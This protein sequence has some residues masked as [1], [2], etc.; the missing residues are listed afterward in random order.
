[1]ISLVNRC[2]P[3]WLT[4][5]NE[6][7]AKQIFVNSFLI[8]GGGSAGCV[9]AR[10]LSDEPSNHVTLLE[11]GTATPN[12]ILSDPKQWPFLA[13]S[14]VDWSFRTTVQPHTDSRTHDWSRGKV[15]GGSSSINAM[16]HVRGHPTDFDYW[17]QNGCDGWGYLDLLPYFIRSETSTYSNSPYHGDSGPLKLMQPNNPHVITQCYMAAATELGHTPT[18]E[19]NGSCMTGPTLNTLTIFDNKR[20]SVAD[21]Y[22]TPVLS[23]DN[24]KIIDHC[25]V[26]QLLFDE[27]KCCTGAAYIRNGKQHRIYGNAGV[28]LCGGTIG[29]PQI[30]LRSGIG[31]ADQL[32]HLDIKPR[33]NLCGVGENLHDHCLG[34]GNIYHSK[35]ALPVSQHQ[36]SESL[37]Y[38]DTSNPSSAP[39]LV[40]ACVVLPVATEK[41]KSPDPGSAYTL[42][43]GV[44]SP[45]S[46]GFLRL[47]SSDPT[48]QP[49][50]NPRYL[51]E[52]SD[53]DLFCEALDFA[54]ELGASQMFD[55]W[56][57]RE[58][59]PGPGLTSEA[60]KRT[61]NAAA[62]YTHHHPVGTCRMGTDKYAV[63]SPELGVYGINNLF[64]VDA[65]IMPR[66]TTGPTNAAVIAVAEKASD[67]LLQRPIL[68]PA[69]I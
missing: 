14:S 44:T 55:Q 67:I 23:R 47:Q 22:L 19:H 43:Y 5:R 25:L 4:A 15:L 9:L 51:S 3:L 1:M 50:I 49:T 39:D 46:R 7:T 59:L 27:Q 57:E 45:K 42:M 2:C 33:V 21:A 13:G 56:R 29:S 12:L 64:V 11:A 53:R 30:L 37:L 6:H 20:L 65:S 35:R 69:S 66:I 41:F 24:L 26:D 61:F 63:V 52:A 17:A 8:I 40:F 38:V 48:A 32:E 31:A 58:Y 16:A 62:A 54:R 34:A 28:I 36:H 18:D 68:K 60:E 10:R